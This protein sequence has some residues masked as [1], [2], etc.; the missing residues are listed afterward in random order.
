[1]PC[2]FIEKSAFPTVFTIPISMSNRST[3]WFISYVSCGFWRGSMT[4]KKLPFE[5]L[6]KSSS[7][8][9]VS[10]PLRQLGWLVRFND[11]MGLCQW[12]FRF[13]LAR[14]ANQGG[15]WLKP[16]SCPPRLEF[17]HEV[18]NLSLWNRFY[19]RNTNNESPTYCLSRDLKAC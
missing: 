3:K 7:H 19:H 11:P 10:I 8:K 15:S 17:R 18:D 6:Q 2:L 4:I 5:T 1:M 13:N 9:I 16:I 12:E 14:Q